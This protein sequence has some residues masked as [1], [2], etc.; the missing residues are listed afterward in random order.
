[1]KISVLD[2]G[3]LGDDISFE[4]LFD[5]GETMIYQTTDDCEIE[6]HIGDSDVIIVNKIKLNESNL[7]NIR[8]LKL[9]CVAATGYD[10]ID[11]DYCKAKGIA[12]CNV[13]GYST[14][15]VTQVTVATALSLSTNLTEFTQFV[16][17]GDYSKSGV[18]NRLMPIYHE[19]AGKTWGII[20]MGNIGKQVAK[21]A[22]ALGC[23]VV[24]YRR[25]PDNDYTYLPLDEL[26]RVSDIISLHLPLTDL[27]RGLISRDVV[28][29]MKKN[30]I[31]I[32]VARGAI[33]DEAALADA[34]LKGN[35]GGLGVDVYSAEPFPVSHPFSKL[36]ANPRVCMTP[37]MAWGSYESRRRCLGEIV[38]NI[39]SFWNNETRNRLDI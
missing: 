16:N 12:V 25:T 26:C 28:S 13:V 38:Q 21:V 6:E 20:G 19:L 5:L 32:N 10:N 39:Q 7:N 9:I 18:A 15:S 3:T 17:N 24:G 35:I 1:M 27:T 14:D 23:R 11:I 34:I 33:C 36:L 8:T 31:F 22:A 2:A 30:A 4:L 37:H 29:Q